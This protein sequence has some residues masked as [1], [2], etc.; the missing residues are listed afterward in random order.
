MC[1]WPWLPLELVCPKLLIQVMGLGGLGKCCDLAFLS[2]LPCVTPDDGL[3]SGGGA[4]LGQGA[5]LVAMGYKPQ[6]GRRAAASFGSWVPSSTVLG[7]QPDVGS[8]K[9]TL[10]SRPQCKA[11]V[12]SPF[13]SCWLCSGKGS[14]CLQVVETAVM[15]QLCPFS[16]HRSHSLPRWPC[17]CFC[18]EWLER[19]GLSD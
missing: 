7:A 14:S 2:F 18:V 10:T 19:H 3:L 17:V 11:S 9:A 15:S 5:G 4:A 8:L 6:V 1:L 13:P 12:I 16:A